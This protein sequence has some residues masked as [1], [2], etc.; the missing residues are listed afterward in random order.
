MSDH[1][2]ASEPTDLPGKRLQRLLVVIIGILVVSLV[3]LQFTKTSA[4][5]KV[6]KRLD[7][8]EREL[9]DHARSALEQQTAELLQLSATPLAWAIRSE[10]MA[11]D[12]R[13]V[14]AYMLKLV[15]EK[16]IKRIALVGRTGTIVAATNLKLKG[17]SGAA[18]FPGLVLVGSEARVLSEDE[19]L[20][21]VVPVMDFE[22]Q[23]GT[24]ILDYGR[25]SIA[26]KLPR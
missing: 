2:A 11:G 21:V 15:K 12:L 3:I 18:A 20:R 4:I 26:T 19:H 6:E 10:M 22:A 23:I 9:V 7:V 8:R 17:Q 13:N 5:A 25:A 16:H 14:D 24:L 1:P